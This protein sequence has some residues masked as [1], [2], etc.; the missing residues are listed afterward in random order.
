MDIMD[1]SEVNYS[2]V[3]VG[4]YNR[5]ISLVKYNTAEVLCSREFVGVSPKLFRTYCFNYNK[6]QG[7]ISLL[8]RRLH[9]VIDP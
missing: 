5:Q 7:R 1:Q 6:H 2:L 8:A 3:I 4:C 9:Q